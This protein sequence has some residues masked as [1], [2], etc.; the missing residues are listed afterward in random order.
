[1]CVHITR[2]ISRGLGAKFRQ[3]HEVFSE[4]GGAARLLGLLGGLGAPELIKC[5]HASSGKPGRAD[6]ALWPSRASAVDY[7]RASTPRRSSPPR[8]PW[9]TPSRPARRTSCR[10]TCADDASQ[11]ARRG[12]TAMGQGWAGGGQRAWLRAHVWSSWSLVS[13]VK[14]SWTSSP[15]HASSW[16]TPST[17]AALA[18][19]CA[20][21]GR[22][23]V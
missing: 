2:R 7:T 6:G 5:A 17:G 22:A 3:S 10:R 13:Q 8:T 15:A 19:A 12:A 9:A 23:G 4:T 20:S 1:M 14:L 21:D 11:A 18:I 16:S